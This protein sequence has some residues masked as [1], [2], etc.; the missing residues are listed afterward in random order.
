MDIYKKYATFAHNLYRK[1]LLNHLFVIKMKKILALL[2]PLITLVSCGNTYNQ[3]GFTVESYDVHVSARDWQYTDYDGSPYSN[4]YF[5]A[6][7]EV[8]EITASVFEEGEVQAFVVYDKRSNDP[9]KHVLP[10]VRHY[11]E[12]LENGVWN[13]YTETVDCVYGIGWVEFNYRASDFAYEDHEDINPTD[14]DFTIVVTTK[15]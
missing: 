12:L 8:P 2:L 13:Y 11:E 5:Y 4:N 14:M 9:Y 6:V 10:Y 1:L 15:D 7:V 3:Y